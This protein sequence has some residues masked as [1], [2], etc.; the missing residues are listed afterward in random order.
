MKVYLS[1]CI[2]KFDVAP[3]GNDIKQAVTTWEVLCTHKIPMC[4]PIAYNFAIAVQ[5]SINGS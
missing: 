2:C 5:A 4:L 3:V 1:Y